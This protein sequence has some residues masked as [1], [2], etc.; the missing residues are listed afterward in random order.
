MVKRKKV[1]KKNINKWEKLF[2]LNFKN[3]GLFVLSWIISVIAH[4]FV[5]VLLKIEEPFFFLLAVVILPLYLSISI[6]YTLF[7][8]FKK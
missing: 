3:L 4:N 6:L 8:I 5:S 2:L 7:R 1:S